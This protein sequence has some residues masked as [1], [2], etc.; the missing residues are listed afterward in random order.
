MPYLLILYS[1]LVPLLLG[2]LIFLLE[3]KQPFLK[4]YSTRLM[5]LAYLFPYYFIQQPQFPPQLVGEYLGLLCIL[6]I[7]I[8]GIKKSKKEIL[9]LI[10]FSFYAAIS[11]PLLSYKFSFAS[12]ASLIL[13]ISGFYCFSFY[14]GIHHKKVTL[15][16]RTPHSL[17]SFSVLNITTGAVTIFSGSLVLGLLTISYGMLFLGKSIILM[18]IDD[19]EKKRINHSSPHLLLFAYSLLLLDTFYADINYAVCILLCLLYIAL[20]QLSP[21]KV[22]E[23]IK[24]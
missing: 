1:V 20:I 4:R 19:I 7:A 11:W 5:L 8:V 24:R 23:L 10:L 17:L 9:S 18:K 16:L 22:K 14:Y 15:S 12:H 13:L 2:V 6:L 21:N 3:N